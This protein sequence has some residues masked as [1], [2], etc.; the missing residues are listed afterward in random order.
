M[1]ARKICGTDDRA[2]IV[3]ILNVIQQDNKRILALFLCFC[4]NILYLCILVGCH[5]SD[6]P[7]MNTGL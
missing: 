3:R 4:Q 7:L 6:N 2:E 5:I 1:C